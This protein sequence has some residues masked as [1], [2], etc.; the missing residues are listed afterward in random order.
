MKRSVAL[1]VV[2][3]VFAGCAAIRPTV[4][5]NSPFDHAAAMAQLEE[6]N[7]TITGSAVVR[8]KG[9]GVVTCAGADISLIPATPYANERMMHIYGTRD[10]GYSPSGA[11]KFE[12]DYPEY[13][14]A[15]RT[16]VGDAQGMFEFDNVKDGE[17][18]VIT[19]ITWAVGYSRQGGA[20]MSRVVVQGGETKKVVLSP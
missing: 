6:G 19:V 14:Q 9:G 11:P 15:T 3:L 2:L 16:V 17:Y 1:L 7:N 4:N 8:Q 20:L 13:Y 12:P 5:L 18:Y 10:R